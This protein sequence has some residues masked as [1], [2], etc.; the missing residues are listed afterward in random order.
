[1]AIITFDTLKFVEK[2]KAAGISEE[3]AKAEAEALSGALAESL[4][5]QV[6]TK[7]DIIRLERRVDALDAKMDTRFERI[8]GEMKL[9]RWMLGVIIVAEVAPFFAKLFTPVNVYQVR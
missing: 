9:N 7:V 6:A 5:T 4:D 3:H 2:L 1:M 8:D